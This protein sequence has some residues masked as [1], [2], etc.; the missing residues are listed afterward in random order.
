M[1]LQEASPAQIRERGLEVLAKA[2]G[3]IGMVRFLQQFEMGSGNYTRD[4]ERWLK[5]VTVGGAMMEIKKR[6]KKAAR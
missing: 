6:R 4:R 2:L 3:P 1:R 5:D